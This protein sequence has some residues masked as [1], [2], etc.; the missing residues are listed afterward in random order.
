[1]VRLPALHSPLAPEL[2][3]EGNPSRADHDAA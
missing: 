2:E 1:V 3:L